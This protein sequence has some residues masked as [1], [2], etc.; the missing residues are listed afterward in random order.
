[1]GY[2]SRMNSTEKH[3]AKNGSSSCFH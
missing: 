3:I 2:A 1:M